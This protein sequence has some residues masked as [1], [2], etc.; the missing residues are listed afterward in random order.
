MFKIICEEFV[1]KILKCGY[2]KMLVCYIDINEIFILCEEK[3]NKELKCKYFFDFFCYVNFDDLSIKC[4][5]KM[6][7]IIFWCGYIVFISC[8]KN[9]DEEGC[10]EKVSIVWLDCGY[11]IK[12]LCYFDK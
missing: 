3:V 9:L 11:K 5:E 8:C 1:D 12:E 7:K 10:F 6:K 2:I 4:F